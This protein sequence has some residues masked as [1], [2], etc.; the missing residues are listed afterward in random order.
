[1]RLI[2]VSM[3]DCKR[4]VFPYIHK[5]LTSNEMAPVYETDTQ[6]MSDLG[7]ILQFVMNDDYYPTFSDK[8]SYLLCSLAGAQYFVNGNKRVGV[9]VLLRFLEINNVHLSALTEQQFQTIL[10]IAFPAHA[11]EHNRHIRNPHAAFLYNL[12]IVIGDKARWGTNDFSQLKERVA[13]LFE[14][15]YFVE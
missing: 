14:H 2:Y 8:T 13:A 6:G 5:N 15:S 7:K 11:W 10:S 1:M 12:A 9:V 4:T 3:E